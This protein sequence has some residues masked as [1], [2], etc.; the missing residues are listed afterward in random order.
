MNTRQMEY[1]IEIANER[2]MQRA[3]NKMFVSQSTLSQTLSKLEK[4]LNCQLFTRNIREMIPTRAG[5][6]AAFLLFRL[7]QIYG[8]LI[9]PSYRAYLPESAVSHGTFLSLFSMI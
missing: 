7:P 4:E 9:S 1:I 5:C 3:A 6:N 8:E 2:N